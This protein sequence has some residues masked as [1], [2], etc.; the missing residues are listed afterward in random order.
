[1]NK[2]VEKPVVW[3]SRKAVF[4]LVALLLLLALAG[5][6]VLLT[7]SLWNPGRNATNTTRL[8]FQYVVRGCENSRGETRG[9]EN[10]ENGEGR[11][12]IIVNVFNNTITVVHYLVYFCCAKIKAEAR[13]NDS[14][15]I[16]L[17]RNTGDICRCLCDYTVH[18]R[19]GNLEP[20][21]YTLKIYGVEFSK[22]ETHI[23]PRL[24]WKGT[25]NLKNKNRESGV[26]P[27]LGKVMDNTSTTA[28]P[29]PEQGKVP[30]TTN[31]NGSGGFCGWS[32]GGR[33]SSD[34]ECYV[35]GCSA[36]VCQSVH[37]KP[38]ITT[39]EVRPC[40]DSAKYGMACRCVDGKCMWTKIR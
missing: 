30:I 7:K 17:E 15:I 32:T 14:E 27:S 23:K 31:E 37:E 19:I 33:C 29:N 35:S 25:V 4:Q 38:V 39:C 8:S 28:P 24:L 5:A 34:S 3:V 20:K 6:G 9:L 1:M 2:M 21:T 16:I 12:D 40:Y 36:Q 13:K 11:E 22:G 10:Y 18:M 26:I